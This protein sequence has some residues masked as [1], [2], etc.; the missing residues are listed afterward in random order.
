MI[1]RPPPPKDLPDELAE[2]FAR[3]DEETLRRDQMERERV[4]EEQAKIKVSL[5]K[6]LQARSF[7]DRLWQLGVAF[8]VLIAVLPS[9]PNKPV[10]YMC[11]FIS[12]V[13]GAFWRDREHRK[14]ARLLPLASEADLADV[15]D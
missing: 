7:A 15:A 13:V 4:R 12:V 1:R 9:N 14:V 10:L 3:L 6:A 11:A 2:R 8:T 5:A